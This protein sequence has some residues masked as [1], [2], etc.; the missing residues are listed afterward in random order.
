ML[1]ILDSGQH[2][3]K[4]NLWLGFGVVYRT[5]GGNRENEVL[6]RTRKVLEKWVIGISEWSFLS[7]ATGNE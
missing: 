3:S 2:Q 7:S 5:K 4:M 1:G 6:G